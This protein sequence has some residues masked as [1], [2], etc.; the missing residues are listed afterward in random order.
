LDV[1]AR[2]LAEI[3]CRIVDLLALRDSLQQLEAEGSSLPRDDV[4]GDH[5]VCYLL[6]IIRD[7]GQITIQKGNF[8]NV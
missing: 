5:C 8:S 1:T 7:T 4:R 2:R 6:K 3:D